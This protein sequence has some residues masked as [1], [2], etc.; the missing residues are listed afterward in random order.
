MK[1]KVLKP[2]RTIFSSETKE[3]TLE[4]DGKI[5]MIR[6]HEDD[7]HGEVWAS[8][9]DGDL[10]ESFELEDGELRNLIDGAATYIRS[11]MFDEEG[12]EIDSEEILDVN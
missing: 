12:V 11:G 7:N 4:I 2:Q 5:I 3:M 8:I 1:I 9:D 6:Q 10:V